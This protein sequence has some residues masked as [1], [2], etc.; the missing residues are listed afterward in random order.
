MSPV[1]KEN[2]FKSSGDVFKSSGDAETFKRRLNLHVSSLKH[3][4]FNII[5]FVFLKKQS[6]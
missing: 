3:C 2:V 6:T 5:Q 1:E 4:V